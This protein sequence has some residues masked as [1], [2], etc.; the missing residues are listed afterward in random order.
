MPEN[1]IVLEPG[2]ERAQKIAKAMA[3]Q[4]AS[5]IL[6]ILSDSPKSLTEITEQLT[7]PL[8]TAKY[9]VENLLDAGLLRI[10]DTKYSI[11][12]REVKIYSLSDQLFIVAPDRSNV[13]SILLKYA[14]LFGIVA[15][16]TVVIALILPIISSTNMVG[17]GAFPTVAS[18]PA[19]DQRESGVMAA[20]MAYNGLGTSASVTDPVLAF[21]IGGV[22]VII[23]LLVYEAYLWKKR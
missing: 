17:A 23:V 18:V 4:T 14:S 2:D 22:F 13:R 9:H 21:F 5:D 15:L 12:G 20:K 7:L 11:K 6:R 8:T 1:V 16:G 10:T 3:S 19:P